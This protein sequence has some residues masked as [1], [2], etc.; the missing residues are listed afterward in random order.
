MNGFTWVAIT[1]NQEL[2][3]PSHILYSIW[4][5]KNTGSHSPA[6]EQQHEGKKCP[7]TKKA[8]GKPWP[9]SYALAIY[10]A[11]SNKE[12]NLFKYGIFIYLTYAC[13][14][15]CPHGKGTK[16]PC[17]GTICLLSSPA[18]ARLIFFLPSS[19]ELLLTLALIHHYHPYL[20]SFPPS[21]TD[22]LLTLAKNHYH[23]P[24]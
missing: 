20:I 21:Y 6:L 12:I 7:V 17:G 18:H 5:V 15:V 4:M 13:D 23:N 3:R 16:N 11:K 9:L 2:N 14:Y 19:H 8:H 10:Q 22:L 24:S 1:T